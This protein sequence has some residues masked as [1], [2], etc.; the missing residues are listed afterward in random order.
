MVWLKF[1]GVNYF[2]EREGFFLSSQLEIF[3]RCAIQSQF[4][5][6]VMK[7]GFEFVGYLSLWIMLITTTVTIVMI[8]VIS[9]VL[10]LIL[11]YLC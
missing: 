4:I 8:K 6:T 1:I 7:K 11:L 3:I 9:V 5:Y 10:I 2:F